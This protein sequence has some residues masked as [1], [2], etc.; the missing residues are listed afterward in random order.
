MSP[1][2]NI[3]RFILKFE[4][5]LRGKKKMTYAHTFLY[6]YIYINVYIKDLPQAN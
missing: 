4:A 2:H 1:I 6:K 5:N 3:R